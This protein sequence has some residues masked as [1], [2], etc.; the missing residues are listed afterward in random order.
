MTVGL[1]LLWSD[2]RYVNH[3]DDLENMGCVVYFFSFI[4][5]IDHPLRTY[6][7]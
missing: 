7:I 1:E 5:S 4:I 6:E 3:Q 2:D